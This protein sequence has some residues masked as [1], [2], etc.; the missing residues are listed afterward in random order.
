MKLLVKF[1][2]AY[3]EVNYEFYCSF[4]S[5][6]LRIFIL[7]ALGSRLLAAFCL[8][9]TPF[10]HGRQ[11][12]LLALSQEDS[13]ALHFLLVKL[14]LFQMVKHLLKVLLLLF[15]F[16]RW[17]GCRTWC[18]REHAHA[19]PLLLQLALSSFSIGADNVLHPLPGSVVKE[20]PRIVLLVV[21]LL[22][23]LRMLVRPLLLW[24][25]RLLACR[26][27]CVEPAL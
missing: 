1:I 19:L 17:S 20:V 25:G 22:L 15:R 9:I 16:L 11:R 7:F 23:R 8:L 14:R 10:L 27:V 18:R 12:I 2:F 6:I 21:G 4:D 5:S 3:T 24:L 26:Y 13:C